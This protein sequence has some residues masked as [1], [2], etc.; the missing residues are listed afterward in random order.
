MRFALGGSSSLLTHTRPRSPAATST[1][2]TARFTCRARRRG[3]AVCVETRS[4][5]NRSRRVVSATVR[6]S[7]AVCS[8]DRSVGIVPTRP[9]ARRVAGVRGPVRVRWPRR[10]RRGLHL[11][12][13]AP[14]LCCAKNVFAGGEPQAMWPHPAGPHSPHGPAEKR[15]GDVGGMWHM[16]IDVHV[17][18]GFISVIAF[19]AGRS[20]NLGKTWDLNKIIIKWEVPLPLTRPN[21]EHRDMRKRDTE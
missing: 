16:M 3:R 2:T 17:A 13:M 9:T 18:Y 20:L 12:R 10:G 8:V 4:D 7:V 6:V 19:S 15:D 5:G 14:G 21:S 11:A 1:A